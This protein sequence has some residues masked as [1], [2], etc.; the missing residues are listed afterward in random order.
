MTAKDSFSIDIALSHPSCTPEHISHALSIQPRASHKAGHEISNLRKSRTHFYATLQKGDS[1][2]DYENALSS[3]VLFIEK[4]AA[5]WR[6]FIS[7]HGEVE[8]ILNHTL[9]EEP[10][11]G[12]LSLQLRLQ[13]DFLRRL[14]TL[15]IGLRVQG[16]NRE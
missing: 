4:N 3:A 5:F 13:P 6:D 16:W 1:A 15:G 8:I 7:G 12:D 10:T 2:V 14:S 11:Q 9:L